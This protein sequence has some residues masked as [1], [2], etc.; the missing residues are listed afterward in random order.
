VR[1]PVSFYAFFAPVKILAG[2]SALEHVPFELR[3]LGAS[4]PMLITDAGVRDAGLAAAVTAALREGG[5]EPGTT[6]DRVPPDSSVGVVEDCARA[7]RAAG[8][9]S[10]LALGG[11]SV[12]DTAKGVSILIS[13]NANDLSRYAGSGVL[14]K[15]TEPL[16]VVPTTSGTG[17]EVT[18]AAVIADEATGIKLAFVSPFLIPDVAVLDPRM[19]LT[20]P[21]R[22]T[23]AT[24][25]DAM[26]HAI[27]AS[28]GLAKN[29][30]SDGYASAAIGKISRHLIPA[31]DHPR[32]PEHRFELA[33]FVHAAH[34][35]AATNK[36]PL[37]VKLRNRWPLRVIFD[38]LADFGILK[39][40]DVLKLNA[41]LHQ[42]FNN[43][44]RESTHRKGAVTLH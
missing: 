5:I 36:L 6:Y 43:R 11:G 40:V 2:T 25:M 29:P 22:I 28:I 14:S 17:S 37:H 30:V 35:I 23:A 26:T 24:A 16:F 9:D 31:L 27:E 32:D 8:C 12:I 33:L 7:H 21:P 3:S 41:A 10:I 15:R 4:H 34:D 20:L 1:D 38:P 44:R 42:D 19:T 18:L 13:E 39:N